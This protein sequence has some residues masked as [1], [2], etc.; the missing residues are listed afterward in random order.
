MAEEA[1]S[2]DKKYLGL[3]QKQWA[4][5]VTVIGGIASLVTIL[6]YL[7]IEPFGEGQPSPTSKPPCQANLISCSSPVAIQVPNQSKSLVTLVQPEGVRVSFTNSQNGSGVAFK[8][9]EALPVGDFNRAKIVGSSTQPFSFIVEYKVGGREQPVETS[10]LPEPFPSG[11]LKTVIV[12]IFYSGS[13]DEVVLNFPEPGYSS[14][15]FIKS[16]S[17]E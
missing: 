7:N 10:G 3:S 11:S 15:F 17:L 6:S 14:D 1:H 9:R 5:A 16:I 13:V 2:R 4:A 8:L 12:P